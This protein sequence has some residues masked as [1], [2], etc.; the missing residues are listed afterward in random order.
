MP[1]PVKLNDVIEALEEAGQEHAHYLDKRSGDIVL[2]T[3]EEMEAAEEDELISEYP[4]WQRESILKA[5]EI[6]NSD[7]NF[8]AMPDQSDIHEYK[9]MED[10]C[11]AF[12][13]PHVG[14]DLRR[15]IKGSGAFGRFKN[16][17]YS[18]GAD[19][20]WYQFRRMEFE[21]IAIEWLEQEGIPYTRQ[22]ATEISDA[23]M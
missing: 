9:I 18:M 6:L 2:I 10:F 1:L 15:L 20:A 21:R 23:K 8:I 17:I 7:E 3:N 12:E 11:L 4:D 5:R 16:A 14:E 19:K 13:D 22:D